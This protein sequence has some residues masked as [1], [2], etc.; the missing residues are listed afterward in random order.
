MTNVG[1][2]VI[3]LLT[4]E[5]A[6]EVLSGISTS[7]PRYILFKDTGRGYQYRTEWW[8]LVQVQYGIQLYNIVEGVTAGRQGFRTE[9]SCPG[10]RCL[11]LI[12]INLI[13]T[14]LYTY[15]N[16][17]R[18]PVH[19]YRYSY[20]TVYELKHRR[21]V[22]GT[23][24]GRPD[25]L[26]YGDIL[27]ITEEGATVRRSCSH[28]RVLVVSDTQQR[29]ARCEAHSSPWHLTLLQAAPIF[30]ALLPRVDGLHIR[31]VA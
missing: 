21:Q 30:H 23:G 28:G 7:I 10:G 31:A 5:H 17:T 19:V 11:I 29:A 16:C 27:K 8:Y 24:R 25:I 20:N 22:P 4:P 26:V 1:P 15:R 6:A 9:V 2:L 13:Y 14:L 12:L 18:I 3:L